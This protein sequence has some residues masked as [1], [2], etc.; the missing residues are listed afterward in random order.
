MSAGEQALLHA[1][2]GGVSGGINSALTGSDVGMGITTSAVSAGIADY[3]GLPIPAD[4]AALFRSRTAKE[5][6]TDEAKDLW[7]YVQKDP[8]NWN[9]PKGFLRWPDYFS[10]NINLA[11]TNPWTGT[12]VGWSGTASLDRNGNWYWSP[13]GAGVGKSAT[14]ISASLTA[15]WMNQ[16]CLP[17]QEQ[18]NNFLSG[19]GFNAA[20]GYWGG[21]SETWSPGNG[22]ATGFGFVT[23]QA[24]ASYN[25][26]FQVFRNTR[27]QW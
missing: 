26:S 15:N 22:S 17:S 1:A 13:L 18:L 21:F 14:I 3:T 5:D 20:A 25:Y 2:A 27:L 16:A 19:H 11:I 7:G 10:A 24:G 23:P 9:D 8:V 12:L 6:S 4:V